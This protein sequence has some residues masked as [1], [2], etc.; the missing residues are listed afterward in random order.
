MRRGGR[1]R[2]SRKLGINGDS[3]IR[4]SFISWRAVHSTR[5]IRKPITGS[6][7]DAIRA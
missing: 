3:S 7:A 2:G 1:E 4:G 5:P 6:A